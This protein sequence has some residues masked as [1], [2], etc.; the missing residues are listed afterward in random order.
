MAK[1][2]T[3][4]GLIRDFDLK[5]KP[6]RVFYIVILVM[7]FLISFIGFAPLIWLALSGF[8]DIREFV[9]ETTILPKAFDFGNYIKTWNDLKFIRY[10]RNSLISVI[11]SV[12]CAVFFNGLL[13]YTLSKIKPKGSK[14]IFGMVI[15]SLLIPATVSVVPLFVNIS[16]LHLT[17][18]FIP[19]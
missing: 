16:R 7:G 5:Q 4:N 19:L 17:G 18:S 14:V 6:V 1:T 10:Y 13:G 9:R 2:Q 15:W 12:G 8:K 11:G 3:N